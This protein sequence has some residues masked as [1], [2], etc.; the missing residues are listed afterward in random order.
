MRASGL[1]FASLIALVPLS[2]LLFS[3]FSAVGSF[4]DLVEN[5]QGFLIRQ[6]VPASQEEIMVYVRR[7]VENTWALGVVGLVFF[8]V[9]SV[10]LLATY[11]SVLIVGGFLISIGLN[12]TGMLRSLLAR[13][14]LSELERTM[15]LL[16]GLFP[17]LFIFA[18]LLLMIRF[19]PAGKVQTRSAL[20]GTAVGAVLWEVARR[21]FFL[22]VTY[23]IR[24]SIVYG[25]LAAI[26][27]F[28]IWLSVAWAIVLGAL[29]IAFV[30]Q[31]GRKGW[32]GKRR[33]PDKLSRDHLI[34]ATGKEQGSLV[35]ARDLETI[36][37][38]RGPVGQGAADQRG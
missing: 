12:L 38:R 14:V 30:H 34:L 16:L 9:T 28:L 29:E 7:C 18:A 23:V 22:W 20:L 32:S 10:F 21:I 4:T 33:V 3:L 17:S 31:H 5:L 35:P 19:I 26:P 15:P 8:L 27:I 36:S 24:L 13:S 25:S 37:V 6:L 2:A 11:L 1:A